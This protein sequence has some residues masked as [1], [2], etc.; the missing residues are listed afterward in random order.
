MVAEDVEDTGMVVDVE[1]EVLLSVAIFMVEVYGLGL[2]DF[3]GM[4]SA[5][6]L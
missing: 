3:E 5:M 1:S 2:D 4:R 6:I